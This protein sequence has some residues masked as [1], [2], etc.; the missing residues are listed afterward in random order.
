MP[1][2]RQHRGA[3]PQDRILF[4]PETWPCLREA[5]ADYS[6]LLGR[7]YSARSALKLVGD[8]H[9]LAERQRLA[10]MRCACSEE[11]IVRRRSHEAAEDELPGEGLLLDGYNVLT[12]VEAALSGAVIL[13]GRD[14]C[15]RDIASMHGTFR[16]VEET[17]PAIA[18]LGETLVSLG[19]LECRWYLDSPVSNSGRLKEML[20]RI[21]MQQSWNWHVEVVMN[22]DPVLAAATEIIATAD[23]VILD[24]CWRWF[25][26]SRCVVTRSIPPACVIDLQ[27]R[28]PAASDEVCQ[29]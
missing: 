21:A 15:Y 19:V 23:S 12:T 8:R 24:Q 28:I 6:W 10:V 16:R 14:G 29:W 13:W 20:L 18:L 3:H 22:P 25:N 27:S 1:D 5:V 26:L 11:S 9:Q 2:K 4:A 17:V 7:R